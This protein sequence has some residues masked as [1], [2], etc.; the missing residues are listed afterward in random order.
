MG[1]KSRAKRFRL[2]ANVFYL[3]MGTSSNVYIAISGKP[4]Y[5]PD[6]AR[7][8]SVAFEGVLHCPWQRQQYGGGHSTRHTTGGCQQGPEF[9]IPKD[10]SES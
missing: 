1:L 7:R 5:Q 3:V 10:T 4:N 2:L 6:N 9:V 8:Q